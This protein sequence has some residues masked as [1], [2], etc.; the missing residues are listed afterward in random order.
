MKLTEHFDLK[1]FVRS[2][3]ATAH[4]I[5]NTPPESV[6][7]NLTN[8]CEKVLEPLRQWYGKPIVIGSGYRC[9]K[10][11]KLVGG[12]ANSQHMTGEA[13]DLHLPDNEIGKQWFEY[14]RTHL[15]YD[16]LILERNTVNS[17]RFWIH[18]SIRREPARNRHMT[19]Y[20]LTKNK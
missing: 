7:A 18:V 10:V 5:D 2:A 19:I 13:A 20:C 1:E 8:L 6:V 14:I 12:V 3:T 11:N 4:G 16:Q 17:S 15:P 9:P